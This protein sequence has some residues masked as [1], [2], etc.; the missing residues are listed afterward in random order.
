MTSLKADQRRLAALAGHTSGP[1]AASRWLPATGRH[2]LLP[3][4][5]AAIKPA[6]DFTAALLREWRLDALIPDAVLIAS[7]LAA[8][9]VRHGSRE[10]EPVELAWACQPGELICVVTDSS[11]EPPVQAQPDLGSESGRGLQI[12]DAFADSWGWALLGPGRKAVWATVG[13]PAP[14]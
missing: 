6:R 7:E 11:A 8:N 4:V 2:I 14:R 13:L 9:A 1:P 10:G 12:V 3:P 5:A